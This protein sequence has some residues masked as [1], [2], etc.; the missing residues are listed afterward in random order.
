[1]PFDEKLML[2]VD[3]LLKKKRGVTKLKMF[4][5]ICYL[6][7]G[8]MCCGIE[9]DRLMVR[10]GPEEYDRLMSHKHVTEMDLTGKPLSG[11]IFV[12]PPAFKTDQKLMEWIEIGLS[13]ARTFPKK[14]STKAKKIS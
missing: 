9:K 6:L 13:Y 2:R 1:M 11:L 8:N 3:A 5:G 7:H 12:Y 4:G 14:V 10:V